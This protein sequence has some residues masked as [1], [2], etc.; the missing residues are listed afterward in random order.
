[1]D[2]TNRKKY[3]FEDEEGRDDFLFLSAIPWISFTSFSH[4]MHYTPADSVPRITWGKSFKEGAKNFWMMTQHSD[5]NPEFQFKVLE[6]MKE[7]QVHSDKYQ[8]II[9]VSIKK[10]TTHGNILDDVVKHLQQLV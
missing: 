4:A 6:K 10:G 1:M 2:L 8:S 7:Y 9:P 3:P 5:K